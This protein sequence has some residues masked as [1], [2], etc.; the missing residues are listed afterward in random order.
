MKEE[1]VQTSMKTFSSTDYFLSLTTSW[2]FQTTSM[3]FKLQMKTLSYSCK[4]TPNVIKQTKFSNS[5]KKTIF[6]SWIGLLNRPISIPLKTF[7]QSLRNAFINVSRNC[8]TI[9][10]RV[11]KLDIDMAR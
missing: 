8:S 1:S 5:S 10:Q 3:K 11:W 4:T 9:Q 2:Q 6:Q 7:G